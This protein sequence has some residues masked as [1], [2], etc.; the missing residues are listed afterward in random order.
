MQAARKPATNL[1]IDL[2]DN[3]EH[4]FAYTPIDKV[5][6]L[7]DLNWGAVITEPTAKAYAPQY[8]LLWSLEIGIAVAALLVSGLAAYLANRATRPVLAAADAVEKLGQGELDTRLTVAGQDELAM[9]GSNI[10][11]MAAQLQN[12]LQTQIAQIEQAKFLSEIASM[13]ELAS[14]D[15]KTV[16]NLVVQGT[17]ELLQADRVVVYRFN[18]NW[19]GYIAAE[20]VLPGL[21]H[22]LND[23]IE[24][25]CI[26]KQLIAAYRNGR[27]VPTN[28]VMAAGFHPEHQQLM[29]RLQVKANLVTPILK[30]DEL[31]GL[32]IVH[33]CAETH[34]WQQSEINFLTQLAVQLG[35]ML[36]RLSFLEQKQAVA[37][38]ASIIKDK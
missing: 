19:G 24:D 4:L 36:S 31:F 21:P 23:K 9:L 16:F 7:S 37:E 15:L 1:D 14:E 26:S 29:E 25:P 12:L 18:P 13:R 20:S 33:H 38:R 34:V 27:V 6:G 2:L 11:Q 17:L 22:A 3:T 8:L 10:N 28:D 35:I 5:E 32:L 30:N